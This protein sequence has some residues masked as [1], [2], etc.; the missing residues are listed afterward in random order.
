[1]VASAS[2][3]VAHVSMHA[4]GIA[5]MLHTVS[6]IADFNVQMTLQQHVCCYRSRL[7][8]SQACWAH[9]V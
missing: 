9:E 1:M 8:L 4:T 7:E 5:C 3:A 2:G 6:Y